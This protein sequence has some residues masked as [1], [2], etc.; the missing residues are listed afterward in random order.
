MRSPV[1]ALGGAVSPDTDET[2]LVPPETAPAMAH[3]QEHGTDAVCE[4]AVVLGAVWGLR[5]WGD[6]VRHGVGLP[7]ACAEGIVHVGIRGL[8]R[9]LLN[10]VLDAGDS[11]GQV[12]GS[13]QQFIQF[14]GIGLHLR[15][16]FGEAE[17]MAAPADAFHILGRR[18]INRARVAIAIGAMLVVD[19][20]RGR[21][22]QR[23]GA[24]VHEDRDMGEVGRREEIAFVQPCVEFAQIRRVLS[25]TAQE[26]SQVIARGA[27]GTGNLSTAVFFGFCTGECTLPGLPQC[28]VVNFHTVRIARICLHDKSL[29]DVVSL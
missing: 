19:L 21:W 10:G 9:R 2:E 7:F 23:L 13:L 29:Q 22:R 4:P 16:L 25:T 11:S 17:L 24:R 18:Q 15:M 12:V 27:D 14:V 1:S 8:Q 26:V 5:G 6:K 28:F 20:G 3:E